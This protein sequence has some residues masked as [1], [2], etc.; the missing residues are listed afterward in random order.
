MNAKLHTLTKD[1]LERQENSRLEAEW[2][3]TRWSAMRPGDLLVESVNNA[4]DMAHDVARGDTP[5]SQILTRR[6]RLRSLGLVTILLGVV[7]YLT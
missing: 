3:S 2:Q 4:R 6:H 1:A 7:A 5:I